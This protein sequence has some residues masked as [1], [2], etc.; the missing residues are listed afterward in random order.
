[1]QPDTRHRFVVTSP[2]TAT[3]IRLDV[4]P[5][6]GLAR[7]RVHGYVAPEALTVLRRRWLDALP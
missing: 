4:I 5:D 6:G 2:R 7:L 3:M 1:V